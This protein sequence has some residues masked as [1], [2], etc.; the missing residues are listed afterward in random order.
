MNDVIAN[1][2]RNDGISVWVHYAYFVNPT[3]LTFDL[4]NI[5]EN[6]SRI[7]IFRVLLQFAEKSKKHKFSKIEL[8]FKG[9]VKFIIPGDYFQQ[10][11][12]EYN[13][14]NPIYTTRTFTQYIT[15]PDGLPAFTKTSAGLFGIAE[16]FENFNTFSDEWYLE[17]LASS[18]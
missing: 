1:D 14:E 13:F 16:D 2:S 8:A 7:D 15:R 10:L 11:G 9:K 18:N 17:D 5:S 3:V 12:Q 4:Q 6:K